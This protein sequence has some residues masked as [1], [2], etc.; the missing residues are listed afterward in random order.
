MKDN[1]DKLLLCKNNFF[2]FLNLKYWIKYI[3]SSL[4][5]PFVSPI[6][7]ISDKS[8]IVVESISLKL[9]LLDPA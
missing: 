5:T 2:K 4:K 8:K 1:E 6:S 7:S 3:D 9:N